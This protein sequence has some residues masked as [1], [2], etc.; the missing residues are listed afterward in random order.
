MSSNLRTTLKGIGL[1]ILAAGGSNR[2][3]RPKQ[4]LEFRGKS[5]LKNAL[6]SALKSKCESIAVV[7]GANSESVQNE[8]YGTDH[9]IVF[10]DKWDAGMGSS[11]K[12]G[13]AALINKDPKIRA[14]VI[15]V[16]DQ[17]FLTAEIIDD[18]IDEHSRSKP[19]IAASEYAGTLGVPALFDRELFREISEMDDKKGAKQIIEKF[20]SKAVSVPFPKG[21]I[22][23]DTPE[24]YS[25]LPGAGVLG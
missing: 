18:L 7:L 14:V 9:Q 23:I 6:D 15:C 10:N 17:P 22:D 11:I 21:D 4:L 2:M 5:L 20:R 25:R 3:G 8:L 1:I 16:C 19:L 13:L 12:M 24:D